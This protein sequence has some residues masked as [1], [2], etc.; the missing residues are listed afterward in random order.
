MYKY[1]DI[2]LYGNVCVCTYM[3]QNL[4]CL[5]VY[6]LNYFLKIFLACIAYIM[7]HIVYISYNNKLPNIVDIEFSKFSH[8]TVSLLS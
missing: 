7:L 4:F 1:I 8:K 3:S 2:I 5:K 6:S